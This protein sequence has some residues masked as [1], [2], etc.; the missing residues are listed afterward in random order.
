MVFFVYY[1]QLFLVFYE[2][3]AL[4]DRQVGKQGTLRKT[5]QKA[6]FDIKSG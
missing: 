2:F 6:D 5:L 4:P 1:Q 3:N